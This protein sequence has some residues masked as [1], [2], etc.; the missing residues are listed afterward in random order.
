M[1]GNSVN[2]KDNHDKIKSALNSAGYYVAT[3]DAA[4]MV[5]AN[6]MAGAFAHAWYRHL[7][8]RVHAYE[9]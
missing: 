4:F 5:T 7:R 1:F 2:A 3:V 8:V 6:G 9:L